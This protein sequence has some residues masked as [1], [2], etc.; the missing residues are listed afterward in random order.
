MEHSSGHLL[1][2]HALCPSCLDTEVKAHQSGALKVLTPPRVVGDRGTC[3]R[4]LHFPV[5]YRQNFVDV[6]LIDR[7]SHKKAAT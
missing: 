4:F 1:T 3:F 7:S 2:I 5:K 6:R